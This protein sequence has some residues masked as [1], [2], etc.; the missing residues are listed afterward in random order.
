MIRK[1]RILICRRLSLLLHQLEIHYIHFWSLPR[2]SSRT[3]Y[4]HLYTYKKRLQN[5]ISLDFHLIVVTLHII[6]AFIFCFI[7]FDWHFNLP[8]SWPPASVPS[9]RSRPGSL[10]QNLLGTVAE[11]LWKN[12]CLHTLHEL[13]LIN[14]MLHG[15]YLRAWWLDIY[16]IPNLRCLILQI[17]MMDDTCSSMYF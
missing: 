9:S 3:V 6:F 10:G 15:K 11:R 4:K 17:P 12:W 1:R 7:W 16:V 8:L 2:S 5:E 13:H 14:S